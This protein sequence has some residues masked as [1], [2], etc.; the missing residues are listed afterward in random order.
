MAFI[1]TAFRLWTRPREA[2]ADL[3]SE[4]H[5]VAAAT[6]FAVLSGALSA[7]VVRGLGGPTSTAVTVAVAVVVGPWG[8]GTL[9]L[10]LLRFLGSVEATLASTIRFSSALTGAAPVVLLAQAGAFRIGAGIGTFVGAVVPVLVVIGYSAFA[11]S[12]VFETQRNPTWLAFGALG[13]TAFCWGTCNSVAGRDRYDEAGV[14]VSARADQ[15]A[16]ALPLL[17]PPPP[18]PDAGRRVVVKAPEPTWSVRIVSVP[19]GALVFSGGQYR[20]RA[21]AM[22][23]AP[24]DAGTIEVKLVLDQR[25]K[26]IVATQDQLEVLVTLPPPG[27]LHFDGLYRSARGKQVDLLRFFSDGDVVAVFSSRDVPA[28]R[29]MKVLDR[30]TAKLKGRYQY[31]G[32]RVTFTLGTK[33]AAKD[34]TGVVGADRLELTAKGEAQPVAYTFVKP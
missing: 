17:A 31:E 14:L 5:S 8:Y 33:R 16:P 11:A 24:M 18:P 12:T 30:R 15:P 32:S 34:Y 7:G 23:E 21:P 28:K 13:I 29:A 2:L 19:P 27:T 25:E 10:V 26:V 20:G 3:A 22:L 1:A 6:L 4:E 9:L